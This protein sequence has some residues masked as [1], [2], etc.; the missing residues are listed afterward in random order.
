[1]FV[2]LWVAQVEGIWMMMKKDDGQMALS[3]ATT[4]D[5]ASASTQEVSATCVSPEL[6]DSA[7]EETR[8]AESALEKA[9]QA[10]QKARQELGALQT[11][12]STLRK[13][14]ETAAAESKKFD[15]ILAALSKI[16]TKSSEQFD[17]IQQQTSKLE[18][19]TVVEQ[20]SSYHQA[21]LSELSELGTKSETYFSTLQ[22]DGKVMSG[23][24]DTGRIAELEKENAAYAGELKALR[25]LYDRLDQK[26]DAKMQ[27]EE[28]EK[29]AYFAASLDKEVAKVVAEREKAWDAKLKQ[30]TD[31]LNER[32][33]MNADVAAQVHK[34][35]VTA[36]RQKIDDGVKALEGALAAGKTQAEAVQQATERQRSLENKVTMLEH[37]LRNEE[38]MVRKAREEAKKVDSN[39]KQ[40]FEEREKQKKE[41]LKKMDELRAELRAS[42]DV[43]RLWDEGRR[44]ILGCL[45]VG[46]CVLP[47]TGD[48]LLEEGLFYPVVFQRHA[49]HGRRCRIR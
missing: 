8:A 35:Q 28:K 14:A 48:G 16:Q 24:V 34:K 11:E 22:T 39:L 3:T 15:D 47:F 21:L 29:L 19:S 49:C 5:D 42:Q 12:V 20:M 9:R 45:V 18:Q 4:L 23:S 7:K 30:V 27:Q 43:S 17:V 32:A 31:E 25:E 33:Q 41:Y 37:S 26:Y 10:E 38:E 1:M 13:E 6:L 46:S 40:S 36:L 44:H 2:A